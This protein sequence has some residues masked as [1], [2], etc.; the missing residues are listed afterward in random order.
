MRH[1]QAV[2]VFRQATGTNVIVYHKGCT[3]GICSAAIGA[4]LL[5]DFGNR[6]HYF[7][8]IQEPRLTIR[9]Y[10]AIMRR[11]PIDVFILDL[12][13]HRDPVRVLQMADDGVNINLFDHHGYHSRSRDNH[14]GKPKDLGQLSPNIIDEHSSHWRVNQR[15]EHCSTSWMLYDV[16]KEAGKDSERKA[17]K[18]MV[19]LEADASAHSHPQ[20]AKRVYRAYERRD[21]LTLAD[22]LT[23]GADTH[24]IVRKVVDA[25]SPRE[26]LKDDMLAARYAEQ[27][28]QRDRLVRR[29][30][31]IERRRGWPVFYEIE[32][33]IQ[34]TSQV[35]DRLYHSHPGLTILVSQ[36][37][38]KKIRISARSNSADMQALL[39][40]STRDLC[41]GQPG[42]H[43][44]RAGGTIVADRYDDFKERFTLYYR[45]ALGSAN[46]SAGRAKTR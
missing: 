34:F 11:E 5:A 30:S 4:E 41:I 35:A 27:L 22:A 8:A 40:E 43:A 26:L 24:G 45:R 3:D 15:A 9:T 42:G 38:G 20:L 32:A 6:A 29:F 17:W 7:Y 2:S 44:R 28:L 33:D 1:E 10:E 25:E 37:R 36:K 39:Q 23:L 19:G 18:A 46:R 12:D 14:E 13:M 31:K 21:I 16:S